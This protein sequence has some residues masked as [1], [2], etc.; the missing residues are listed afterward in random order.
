MLFKLTLFTFQ[1]EGNRPLGDFQSLDKMRGRGLCQWVWFHSLIIHDL[2]SVK[3]IQSSWSWTPQLMDPMFFKEESLLEFP[4]HV[5]WKLDELQNVDGEIRD[6][7]V[8]GSRE[9]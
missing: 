9:M 6:A 2:G 7:F 3:D 8:V 4:I 5:G 1:D